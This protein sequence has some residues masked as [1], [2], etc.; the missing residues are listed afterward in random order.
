[1]VEGLPSKPW[2]QFSNMQKKKKKKKRECLDIL[3][4]LSICRVPV[5]YPLGVPTWGCLPLSPL[6]KVYV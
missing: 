1:M 3:V 6:S 5:S 2:V 4:C